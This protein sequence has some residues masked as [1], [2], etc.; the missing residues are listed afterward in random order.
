MTD[1]TTNPDAKL[2][3]DAAV[4]ALRAIAEP[5]RLRIVALLAGAELSVKD[6]TRILGQSQPRISRHLKLL[7]DAGVIARFKE[8]AWLNLRLTDDHPARAL[9]AH[10]LGAID[11]RSK[12]FAL[13]MARAEAVLAERSAEA[14]TY[15]A[16]H[17]HRWDEI[18]AMHV[19]EASV[20]RAMLDMVGPGPF[21]TMLDIGTG[22]GRLLEL[23]A[24]FYRR[25][26]GIDTNTAML[27][28]AR[29]RLETARIAH[30]QVRQGDLYG[31]MVAPR[32]CDLVTMHQVLHF[33]DR[34]AVALGEAAG[35]LAPGGVMLVVDFAPHAFGE[36]REDFAHRLLG[37]AD[38]DMRKWL[39]SVG[40]TKIETRVLPPPARA[41]LKGLGV[42]VWCAFAPGAPARSKITTDG[43]QTIREVVR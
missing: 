29:S 14:E 42:M 40:L 18:R 3:G 37:I 11:P 39:S 15:F 36:L 23:F 33:L 8:G 24:P 28:Y 10:V 7:S 6:L 26:I 27:A 4:A 31:M 43:G 38:D 41:G 30:A 34:P 19:D 21:D 9:V 32:S 13:D 16:V 2:S 1:A 20:E 25:G 17:A 35:V 22:T 12:P 5:T